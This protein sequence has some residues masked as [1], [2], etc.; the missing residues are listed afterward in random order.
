[1]SGITELLVLKLGEDYIR[2]Q[3][4]KYLR[5]VLPKASVFPLGRCEE[6]RVHLAELRAV[7]APEAGLFRL[8]I[9]EEPY[10]G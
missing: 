4:G 2:L 8:S 5:S 1:M 6:A 7:G 3:D 10:D 9:A